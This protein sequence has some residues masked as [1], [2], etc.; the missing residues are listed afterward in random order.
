MEGER[1]TKE[2]LFV[3]CMLVLYR[4]VANIPIPGVDPQ[5]LKQIFDS[6]Q[7]L[8][9]INV[10]S[11]GGISNFS[12]V[13]MGVAPYITSSII[14][15]L[16][17]MIVPRL[18]RSQREPDGQQRINKYTMNYHHSTG[19][20]SGFW[21]DYPVFPVRIG[22]GYSSEHD[23]DHYRDYYHDRRNDISCGLANSFRTKDR[24]WDFFDYLCGN[25]CNTA[26]DHTANSVFV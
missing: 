14:Y 17:V 10:F 19:D 6:N 12:I 24:Q 4:I 5:G 15:Q 8:G 21:F 2:Y 3:F 25:C 7:L 20:Y 22:R 13:A 16:L 23:S 9:L 18:R 11:G 26:A 1:D